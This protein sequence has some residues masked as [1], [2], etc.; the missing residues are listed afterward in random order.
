[1]RFVSYLQNRN[2]QVGVVADDGEVVRALRSTVTGRAVTCLLPL[3]EDW[4]GVECTL[5][6][7]GE[8]RPLTSLSLLPPLRPSRNLICVG[9]NYHAHAAEF[10]ISGFDSSA[11]GNGTTPPS[12]EYPI[13]FTKSADSLIGSGAEIE[14]HG[15]LTEGLDYEGELAVIIGK[16]GRAIDAADAWSHVWGYCLLNDVTAR[17]LQKKHKQWFLGKSLDSFGP[18]GPFA[19]T[20]DEV[21]LAIT[22]LIT[23]VNGEKRQDA[24]VTDLIFDIPTLIATV[25]AGVTLKPGDVIATGT[26]EGVG[27]GFHPPRFL[28]PGDEV[29]ITA[30][31][32]GTLTNRVGSGVAA[33]REN[34]GLSR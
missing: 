8:E 30:P 19:V 29:S 26:P 27:I 31:R 16:G 22:R 32:L 23:T 3:L 10:A 2:P 15:G 17:D 34:L 24:L 21:D 33:P 7:F 6:P 1:V 20:A 14:P 12:P 28:V 13:F 18:M 4:P 11:G 25:S 9:K 5:K